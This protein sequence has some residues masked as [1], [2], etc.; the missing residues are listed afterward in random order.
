MY[1]ENIYKKQNRYERNALKNAIVNNQI[2]R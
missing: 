1:L 2:F